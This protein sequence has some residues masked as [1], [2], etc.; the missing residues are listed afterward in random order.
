V[1]TPYGPGVVRKINVRS[2]T[3][4][5]VQMSKFPA[6]A[7]LGSTAVSAAKVQRQSDSLQARTNQLSAHA[8]VGSAVSTPFGPGVVRKIEA[9]SSTPFSVK[10]KN[11]PGTASLAAESVTAVPARV[12]AA[13]VQAR[14]NLLS[15]YASVGTLVETS[16]GRA[17]VYAIDGAALV[18]YHVRF[19][20]HPGVAALRAENFRPVPT[21]LAADKVQA[22]VNALAALASVGSVVETMYGRGTVAGIDGASL[23]PFRVRMLR[24]PAIAYL[25]AEHIKVYVPPPL[26]GAARAAEEQRLAHV[27]VVG[28]TV[29]T[30]FGQGTVVAV[31]LDAACPFQV[32][33]K[34]FP[35]TA[36]VRAEGVKALDRERS[37]SL[38]SPP[39][40]PSNR[41]FKAP[42]PPAPTKPASK[43]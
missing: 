21:R 25:S 41:S 1:D 16:F 17:R 20:S 22:R 29:A 27:A 36:Y 11:F 31:H 9:A 35:A 3:P 32:R 28:D 42:R 7:F 24:F 6:V 18:P 34:V 15:T 38:K 37:S 39:G 30:Q 43:E 19:L 10:L 33:M 40:S 2:A 23:V 8:S 13:R 12:S 4:Y 26:A 14:T 5:Q